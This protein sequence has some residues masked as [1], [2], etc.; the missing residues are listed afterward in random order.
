MQKLH[1]CVREGLNNVY[2]LLLIVQLQLPIV[3]GL[4]QDQKDHVE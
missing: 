1:N 3:A 4:S 2:I